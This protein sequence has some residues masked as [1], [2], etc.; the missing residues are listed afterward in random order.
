[1]L[2]FL[3]FLSSG[4]ALAQTNSSVVIQNF[5]FQ[6]SDLTVPVGATV[7]WT[8]QDSIPHTVTSD[9]GIFDS[10]DI[11]PDSHFSHT[12][13]QSGSYT[14][15]CKIH[16]SM[17]GQIQVTQG[18]S[19]SNMSSANMRND[20]PQNDISMYSQYYRM[21]GGSAPKKHITEP[22]NY[23]MKNIESFIVHFNV[24][25]YAMP[26]MPYQNYAMPSQYQ[27][28]TMPYSQYQ[29]NYATYTGGNSLW[30]QGAT[31]LTQYAAVPQGSSLSLIAISQTGGNG[32]LYEIAPGN[33]LIANSYYFYPYNQ[34]DFYA[35]T[36]GQH[37]LLFIIDDKVSNAVVIDVVGSSGYQQP[38][39]QQP[40]YNQQSYN[41]PSYQQP[42]Y[43]GQSNQQSGYYQ[44]SGGYQSTGGY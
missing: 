43:Q 11:T 27:T 36:I 15:H 5:S 38:S 20:P 19:T 25:N 3:A 24:P 9:N 10:N 40:G 32:Y 28:Y 17:H 1:M 4:S 42:G 39:Y 26:S 23:Q 18:P 29:Q 13:N 44:P 6:P 35:D 2:V 12:F 33:R 30:I 37:I 34:M 22:Q 41:Q 31:S 8:N 16:P 14:Y 21:M 7:T